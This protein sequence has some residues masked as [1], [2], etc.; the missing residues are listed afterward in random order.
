MIASSWKT[1]A[2][3]ITYGFRSP[4]LRKCIAEN[5]DPEYAGKITL[6]F[7]ETEEQSNFN[8][9]PSF[10]RKCPE[11][12][13]NNIK[14]YFQQIRQLNWPP[15][16]TYKYEIIYLGGKHFEVKKKP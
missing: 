7:N 16:K 4:E 11:V 10:W 2:K 15:Y 5:I 6:I 1:A 3:D 13:G 12:R 9:T 8:I 14:A